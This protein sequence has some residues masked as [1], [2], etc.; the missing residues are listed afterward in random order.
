MAHYVMSDLHGCYDKFIKML[1]YIKFDSKQDVIYILGDVLD[2][3]PDGIKILQYCMEKPN[4]FLIM[5]NHEEMLLDYINGVTNAADQYV[6]T[7]YETINAYTSSN[8]ITVIICNY[9]LT[10]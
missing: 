7:C 1:S 9:C 3:G 10:G 5:G 8:L 6:T 2:R 4:I